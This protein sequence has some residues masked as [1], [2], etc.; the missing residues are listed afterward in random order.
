MSVRTR[1]FL[2]PVRY[3]AFLVLALVFSTGSLAGAETAGLNEHL[4]VLRP[5]LGR[6]WQGELKNS[7]PE[8][9]QVDVAR[10]ERAM[11]GQAVRILHSINRGDYGGETLLYWD[12]EKKTLAYHY[13]TTGGF[14]THG[15][16]TV[17]DGRFVAV[18][19]VTGSTSGITEVRATY[20]LK[21]DGTLAS[22]TEYLKD[23]KWIPG[24][25]AVYREAPGTEVVFR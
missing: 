5:F 25:A 3:G 22:S 7:T 16:A 14:Q 10:W 15:T 4:E 20:Q 19:R 2:V 18:E 23:G 11:N 13:I 1:R 8:K 17:V 12:R 21:S 24:H 6:T 9:P